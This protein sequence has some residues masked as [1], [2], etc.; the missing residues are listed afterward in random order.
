MLRFAVPKEV[1]AELAA[2]PAKRGAERFVFND[3]EVKKITDLCVTHKAVAA[4]VREWN[5]LHPEKHVSRSSALRWYTYWENH[6]HKYATTEKRGAKRILPPLFEEEVLDAFRKTRKG[7]CEPIDCSL[8]CACARGIMKKH[9]QG[10]TLAKEGGKYVFSSSWARSFSPQLRQDLRSNDNSV[11]HSR[12]GR[13]CIVAVL[14]RRQGY[15]C[16]A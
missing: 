16:C 12:R 5:K 7:P 15:R 6:E 13:C 8:L 10:P 9:L 2:L 1:L 11:L 3:A 14:Q 4:G